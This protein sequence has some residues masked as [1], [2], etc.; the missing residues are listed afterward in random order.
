M[1]ALIA[2]VIRPAHAAPAAP[3][4]A[5][6]FGWMAWLVAAALLAALLTAALAAA[7]R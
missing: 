4:P 3:P 1:S 7:R 6:S 2:M 5:T